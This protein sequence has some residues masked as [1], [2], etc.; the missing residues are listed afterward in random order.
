M[1]SYTG[2]GLGD[3]LLQTASA[4]KLTETN[5]SGVSGDFALRARGDFLARGLGWASQRQSRPVRGGSREQP[6]FAR[7]S[8]RL[9]RITRHRRVLLPRVAITGGEF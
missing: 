8:A 3:D 7:P 2:I 5:K 6:R 1:S 9:Y 4:S